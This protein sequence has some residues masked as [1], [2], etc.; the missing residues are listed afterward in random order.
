MRDGDAAAGPSPMV[1]SIIVA[2]AENGVIGREGGLALRIPADLARLKRLSSGH[3]LVMGRRT[4]ESIGRPLPGRT[5]I[6]LSRNPAYCAPGCLV[7]GSLEDALDAAREACESEVFIMGGA[8]VYRLA[9]PLAS[10]LYLTRVHAS[11][12]GDTTFP[13]I[14]P[15]WRETAREDH[16]EGSPAAFTFINLL[17]ERD[18]KG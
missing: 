11:P 4:Y 3:H 17:R 8:E 16:P 5:T 2:V 14:G 1:V 13:S 7:R 6:V 15:E 12:D 10:R 18:G 9:L